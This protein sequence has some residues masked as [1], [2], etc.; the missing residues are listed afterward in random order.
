MDKFDLISCLGELNLT[1]ISVNICTMDEIFHFRL[2]EKL[3]NIMIINTA[4]GNQTL[5][6]Y[7]CV[8]RSELGIF[9]F[10]SFGMRPDFYNQK[11]EDYI[12]S[13]KL[14]VTVWKGRL[15]SFRSLACG[16]Y[17]MV[18][19]YYISKYK[20]VKS[21]FDIFRVYFNK[22]YFQNDILV[23]KLMYQLF[24]TLGDCQKILCDP[25]YTTTNDCIRICRDT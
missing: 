15:Q 7:L 19:I 2:D 21:A 9:M 8:I 22:K 3:I 12:L 20:S 11:L 1:D 6:H 25:E 23:V 17:V 24:T 10:D 13:Y 4:V 14:P 16:C 5:G 18:L